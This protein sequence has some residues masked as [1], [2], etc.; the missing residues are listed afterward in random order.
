[1]KTAVARVVGGERGEEEG[2]GAADELAGLGEDLRSVRL[3]AIVAGKRAQSAVEFARL[4]DELLETRSDG[5]GDA[6]RFIGAG[7]Q[8]RQEGRHHQHQQQ[9]RRDGGERLP[10]TEPA[11]QPLI[12]GIAQAGEN[13]RQQDRQQERADHRDERGGDRRDEQEKEGL[14]KAGLCHD[15]PSNNR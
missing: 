11:E 14:A 13:R 6:Q 8:H 2:A 4:I 5:L 15:E 7:P 1:M 10:A 9:Q 12:H 3:D